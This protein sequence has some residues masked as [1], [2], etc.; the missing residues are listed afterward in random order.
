MNM[1]ALIA[2]QYAKRKTAGLVI[3][4]D[5]ETPEATA[6]YGRATAAYGSIKQRDERIDALEW[7]GRNPRIEQ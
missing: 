7:L 3:S 1:E 2:A 4:F 6:E 5:R